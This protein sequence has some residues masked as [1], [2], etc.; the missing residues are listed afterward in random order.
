MRNIA[1]F[2][3]A[4]PEGGGIFQY[5]LSLLK[6]LT[7]IKRDLGFKLVLIY[8]QDD[9]KDSRL[10]AENNLDID[11]FYKF[12]D[13]NF[14]F[15]VLR[16]ILLNSS[17][18]FRKFLL[19]ILKVIG[20]SLRG[21]I[22]NLPNCK[23]ESV[24]FPAEDLEMVLFPE[25]FSFLSIHDL[26]DRVLDDFPSFP[27]V[28]NDHQKRER[29][30]RH[31]VIIPEASFILT[32]SEL[33][34]EHV[35]KYYPGAYTTIPFP[36]VA[37]PSFYQVPFSDDTA[38][39]LKEYGLRPGYLFYPAQFW[40]YKNHELIIR[41][42]SILKQEDIEPTIVFVGSVKEENRAYFDSLLKL[43]DLFALSTRVKILGYVSQGHIPAFYKGAL[44]TVMPTFAGPTNLPI[45]ESLLMG[46]PVIVSDLFMMPI[47]VGKAGYVCDP[48]DPE[49]LAGKLKDI[50]TNSFI[51]DDL[52]ARVHQEAGKFGFAQRQNQLKKILQQ[53]KL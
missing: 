48:L 22:F 16:K 51:Y 33:G 38:E 28:Y 25:A 14:Y 40:S 30:K 46:T 4:Y 1:V 42:L 41:A 17:Q 8:V 20:P 12:D 35:R 49:D 7:N 5:T 18:S 15:R 50:L 47:M 45:I 32:D 3:K 9:W 31:S 36:Y 23:I 6:M 29:F 53:V 52:K 34:E 37:A 24:F 21:K 2:V 43:I 11:S 39:V 44:L 13:K 26:M 27:K 19:W 10:I